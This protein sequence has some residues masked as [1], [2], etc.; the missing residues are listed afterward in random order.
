MKQLD[1]I[2]KTVTPI[3]VVLLIMVSLSIGF[4]VWSGPEFFYNAR[5]TE[6]NTSL[7]DSGIRQRLQLCQRL[8]QMP[9]HGNRD[10]ATSDD[11]SVAPTDADIG[12]SNLAEYDPLAEYHALTEHKLLTEHQLLAESELPQ[13]VALN[14]EQAQRQQRLLQEMQRRINQLTLSQPTASGPDTQTLPVP[15]S[16][17]H[18]AQCQRF[19]E[20]G[21]GLVIEA[22]Q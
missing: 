22:R 3:V 21:R 17:E 5:I 8:A 4:I 13:L 18:N 2:Y 11:P 9:Y 16:D 10:D 19:L 7:D 6:V 12:T 15:L 1:T 14:A 20:L